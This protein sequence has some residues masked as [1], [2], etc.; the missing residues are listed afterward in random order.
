MAQLGLFLPY[1]RG[2]GVGRGL[3]GG[4][5]LG[6][7]VGRGVDVAVG[8]GVAV[9]VTVAAAVGVGLGGVTVGVTVAVPVGVGVG[10]AVGVGVGEGPPCAQYLPPVLKLLPLVPPQTIIS[11]P[12]QI[13]V[14]RYRGEGAFVVLVA[15]QVSVPALYLPPVLKPV[16]GQQKY[17][18]QTIISLPVHTAG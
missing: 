3:G 14:C 8:V 17:P 18:P 15:V 1:G 11:L 13:A 5:L 9:G 6:V 4:V 12:L 10:L 7:S 2:G 16:T